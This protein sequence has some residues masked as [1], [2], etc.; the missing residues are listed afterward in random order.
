MK[1]LTVL[2]FT[3]LMIHVAWAETVSV[4]AAANKHT[5]D[6]RIYGVNNGS[7]AQLNDINA[8]INRSGGTPTSRYNWQQDA[9]NTGNDY[10]F[11]SVPANGAS[12]DSFVQASKAGNAEPMLTVP[13]LDWVAKL[14]AGGSTL[15][16]FSVKKYGPQDGADGDFGTGVKPD[17]T[18]FIT[19]NNP[20]DANVAS[21]VSFQDGWV[22]HLIQQFGSSSANGLRYYLLDQEPGIWHNS[23]RDVHPV[24]ATMQE[25]RDKMMAYS[26]MIKAN[27]PHAIVCGP[28]EWNFEGYLASG[29]D[30]QYGAQHNNFDLH[31]DR[32][33]HGG[34]DYLPYILDQFHQNELAGN[35]RLLDVLAVH[36]YPQD[37]YNSDQGIFSANVSAA[38]QTSRN[39]STRS[40]WDPNYLDD[41][42]LGDNGYKINLIPR[43]K[44]WINQ[45]YPNTKLAINE[46][47][48]GA[49]GDINGATAQADVLGIFGREGVDMACRWEAPAP[50]SPVANAF[51]MYRNYDGNKS[52]FGDMSVSAAVANPDTLTAFAAVRNSDGALTVVVIN[53]VAGATTLQLALTNFSALPTAQ[54]WQLTSANSIAHLADVAVAGGA[55]SANLP[56]QSITLFVIPSTTGATPDQAPVIQSAAQATPNPAQVGQ[57]VS[58]SISATDADGDALTYQWSFGDGT[59]A[60]GSSVTHTF[61]ISGTFNVQAVVSD[62]RGGSVSSMVSMVVTMVSGTPV[63][64]SLV[65]TDGDG[66]S[67][68][69]E[70]AAGT[71]PNDPA[72]TPQVSVLNVYNFNAKVIP[73]GQNQDKLQLTGALSNLPQGFTASGKTLTL[74]VGNIQLA[75]PLNTRNQSSTPNGSLALT[76]KT[77]LNRDTGLKEFIGGD[78]PFRFKMKALGLAAMLGFTGNTDQTAQPVRISVVLPNTVFSS[79][80]NTTYYPGR[81]SGKLVN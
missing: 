48:W 32:D 37:R 3:I 17:H 23:H 12:G 45:Y 49:E 30:E 66:I 21:S 22:K 47:S 38:V 9:V 51:K 2:L 70:I 67:D 25:V 6:P 71:D 44:G 14:G 8:P 73:S 42:Y 35:A 46:Y 16:S 36:Y 33:A 50:G 76:L 80:I 18:T 57:A 68:V 39:V 62:G 26:A 13:L 60:S 75:F 31:P 29:Y 65:D 43:V 72:L 69:L 79:D 19:G 11:E 20:N 81:K 61:G 27:D 24:G 28:D 58:F 78:A 34:M 56:G 77:R 4:D 64:P 40:L 10:F 63:T 54:V 53:K 59:Q 1:R 52:T 7:Q 15:G 5:I 55:V 74:F 41:S